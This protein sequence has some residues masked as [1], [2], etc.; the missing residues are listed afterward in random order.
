LIDSVKPTL[1]NRVIFG[2]AS[3]FVNC[4]NRADQLSQAICPFPGRAAETVNDPKIFGGKS[5]RPIVNELHSTHVSNHYIP[6]RVLKLNVGYLLS[7]G[8]GHTRE[9]EL[10]IPST[11]RIADDLTV[12]Y[13]RGKVVMSRTSRGILVQS[14]LDTSLPAECVRC[15]DEAQVT[16]EVPVEELF[17]YP[18]EDGAAFV[19]DDSGI[20]DLA[21]LI[22]EEVLLAMPAHI[23]CRPDC[24]GL[25]PQCGANR[26]DGPCDCDLDTIDPRLAALKLLQ[27]QLKGNEGGKR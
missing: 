10:D 23:L 11:L 12:D 21:P 1:Y 7:E 17:V 27:Q 9:N 25:C 19:I 26:N 14:V 15:L 20:L 4:C 24:L 5:Q 22:R 6:A 13:L 16:L 18:P 8:P 2:K 3:Y